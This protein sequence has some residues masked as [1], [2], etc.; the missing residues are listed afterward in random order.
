MLESSALV[1]R[2]GMT[3]FQH[4]SDRHLSLHMAARGGG[5]GV[6]S[7]R[8]ESKASSEGAGGGERKRMEGDKLA[9]ADSNLE[10]K[11]VKEHDHMLVSLWCCLAI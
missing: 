11:A 2:L 3:G 1:D 7:H 8:L 9:C 10:S 5:G 6:A 4:N